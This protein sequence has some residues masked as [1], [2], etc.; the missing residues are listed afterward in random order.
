VNLDDARRH[1]H[2]H[3]RRF[4]AFGEETVPGVGGELLDESLTMIQDLLTGNEVK[5]AGRRYVIDCP[6]VLP[7]PVQ[8]LAEL[9]PKLTDLWAPRSLDLAVWG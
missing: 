2:D 8:Y 6:P 3:R 5:H 9:R 1:R 7:A 4:S